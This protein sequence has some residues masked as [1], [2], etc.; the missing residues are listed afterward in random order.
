MKSTGEAAELNLAYAFEIMRMINSGKKLLPIC[1]Y[2]VAGR[3]KDNDFEPF[4]D[5]F[6]EIKTRLVLIPENCW[7]IFGLCL[8]QKFKIRWYELES[9]IHPKKSTIGETMLHVFKDIENYTSGEGDWKG[10][11]S[12]VDI[13]VLDLAFD[14]IFAHVRKHKLGDE[15][16]RCIRA[17]FIHKFVIADAGIVLRVDGT[18]P[19][20][21]GLTSFVGSIVNWIYLKHMVLKCPKI[22]GA[23]SSRELSIIWTQG[24]DWIIKFKKDLQI[25]WDGC[26]EWLEGEFT[27]K[28]KFKFEEKFLDV[29]DDSALSFLRVIRVKGQLSV[30]LSDTF[31]RLNGSRHKPKESSMSKYVY[32]EFGG[33]YNPIMDNPPAPGTES[34]D[35]VLKYLNF[36]VQLEKYLKKRGVSLFKFDRGEDLKGDAGVF[37]TSWYV[38]P[39]QK[40]LEPLRRLMVEK[41]EKRSGKRYDFS[42]EKRSV[43]SLVDI[44][45]VKRLQRRIRSGALP[46]KPWYIL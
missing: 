34:F 7:D 33:L 38:E 25:D 31:D 18:I 28:F 10:F 12:R 16:L 11:D 3:E 29:E 44:K 40:D 6:E 17:S 45:R 2:S 41:Y 21:H 36:S 27:C 26:K 1:V 35:W 9:P 19:S 46:C 14:I 15:I 42:T 30:K 13:Q 37:N 32:K 5:S 22:K 20:G 43:S 8:L 24:D 39:T 23:T 4:S